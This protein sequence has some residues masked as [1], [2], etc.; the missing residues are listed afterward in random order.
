[1]GCT[2]TSYGAPGPHSTNVGDPHPVS[3]H[4]WAPQPH[5]LVPGWSGAGAGTV[6]GLVCS[7][8][9]HGPPVEQP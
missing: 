9:A 3:V 5:P 2:N 7:V 8:G 6:E 1:M 4:M